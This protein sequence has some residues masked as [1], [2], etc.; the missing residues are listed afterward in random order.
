MYY[1]GFIMEH[2]LD[3]IIPEYDCKEEFIKRLLQSINRQKG[4]DLNEIGI[5]IVNDKSK[6]KLRKGIFKNFPKLN[7][8][9][10]LKDINEGVGMTRQYGL[11][12]SKA[13]YVTFVDQDDELYGND[14]LVG[15]ISY[16]KATNMNYLCTYYVE[17]VKTLDNKMVNLTFGSENGRQSLHGVFLKREFLLSNDVKFVP[18][19][20]VHDDYYLRAILGIYEKAVFIKIIS[21]LWKYNENSQV[22]SKKKHSYMV[23]TFDEYFRLMEKINEYKSIHN[24]SN[25]FTLVDN[26]LG[27]YIILESNLFDY[28]DLLDKKKHYEKELFKL[29][30]K[31]NEELEMSKRDYEGLFREQFK[32]QEASNPGLKMLTDETIYDFIKK[33]EKLYPEYEYKEMKTQKFLDIV[34][35][36][37][38]PNGE[39]LD[40][41]LNSII[42][43]TNISLR[44]ISV[45]IVDDNSKNKINKEKLI[46][47]HKLLDIT[48]YEKDKNEGQGLTRQ[49]GLDRCTAKYVTFINQGDMFYG[50]NYFKDIFAT[51]KKRSPEILITD[52]YRYDKVTGARELY[53]Y[54]KLICLRGVFFDRRLLADGNYRFNEKIRNYDDMYF[55]QITLGSL[56]SSY[57]SVPSYIW[58]INNESTTF[59]D[60]QGLQMIQKYPNDYLVANIDSVN[61]LKNNGKL[62]KQFFLDKLYE[63][64]VTI[65]SELFEYDDI[66]NYEKMIYDFYCDYKEIY[67]NASEEEKN[68]AYKNALNALNVLYSAKNV[69]LTFDEFITKM[70]K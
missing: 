68:I 27:L 34:I 38:N 60:N 30:C 40:R 5:I 62:K 69:R 14:S 47:E 13:K 41:L 54:K 63:I 16:L 39:M 49:F 45:I 36:C 56:Q 53:D 58:F 15:V 7:I 10:Y 44:E 4:V 57:L 8:E 26:L 37:Y 70:T 51:L 22:R 50:P 23:D 66:S 9:Y 48:I 21:Y 61:F 18:G 64:F 43:Q 2:F 59:S 46:K 19:F 3:I 32:L 17:E 65:E 31:Y 52:Y 42:G 20:R 11:D 25:S 24:A 35:P 33:M 55:M 12:R 29:A 28:E 6:N 67:D 1:G